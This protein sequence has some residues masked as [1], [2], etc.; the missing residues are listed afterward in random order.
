MMAPGM[1]HFHVDGTRAS[2]MIHIAAPGPAWEESMSPA[3]LFCWHTGLIPLRCPS[4]EAMGRDGGCQAK[5]D[6]VSPPSTGVF[7]QLWPPD[8]QLRVAVTVYQAKLMAQAPA[9]FLVFWAKTDGPG[10]QGVDPIA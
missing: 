4:P 10:V 9:N 3:D 2:T 1:A 7:R 5:T 6:G 8:N